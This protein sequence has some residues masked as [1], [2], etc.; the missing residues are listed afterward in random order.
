[1]SHEAICPFSP[2]AIPRRAKKKRQGAKVSGRAQILAC[3]SLSSFLAK[4]LCSD[5]NL[6]NF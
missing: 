1:M 3:A 4:A 5:L 6:S 2:R